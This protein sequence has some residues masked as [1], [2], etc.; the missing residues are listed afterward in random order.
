MRSAQADRTVACPGLPGSRTTGTGLAGEAAARSYPDPHPASF[1]R[2]GKD[3]SGYVA[4]G[5]EQV[6][7]A[8]EAG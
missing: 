2:V 5:K 4:F 7:V 6:T 1:A 3:Y 8:G